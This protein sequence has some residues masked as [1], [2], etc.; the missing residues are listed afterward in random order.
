LPEVDRGENL[1]AGL[2][3]E[4]ADKPD[5][6]TAVLF[7]SRLSLLFFTFSSTPSPKK[8]DKA[9]GTGGGGQN[10]KKREVRR[11]KGENIKKV[12]KRKRKHKL[13]ERILAV[14]S[15]FMFQKPKY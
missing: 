5:K 6:N 4:K 3:P 13:V 11:I 2:D 14:F 10:T 15:G 7:F 8:S 9:P 1:L 12:I